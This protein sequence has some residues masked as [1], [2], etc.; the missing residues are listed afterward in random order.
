MSTVAGFVGAQAVQSAGAQAPLFAQHL[1]AEHQI[2][3][4]GAFARS[5][6]LYVFAN[7]TGGASG[8]LSQKAACGYP[9]AGLR[10]F[11]LI[12][13]QGQSKDYLYA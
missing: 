1:V 8:Q 6:P 5:T 2:L 13:A 10:T 11:V 4:A 7:L 3:Q 12:L 9:E